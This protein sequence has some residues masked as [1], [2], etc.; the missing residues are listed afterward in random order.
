MFLCLVQ[1][2]PQKRISEYHQGKVDTVNII[3]TYLKQCY[4]NYHA[5]VY[6]IW[7][8][9]TLPIIKSDLQK[10]LEVIDDVIAVSFDTWIFSSELG[11]VIEIYHEGEVWVGI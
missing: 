8:E 7:D 11:Y 4:G 9:G 1:F 3:I 10:V 5:V 2:P 6:V